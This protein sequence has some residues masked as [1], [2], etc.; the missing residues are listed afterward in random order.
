MQDDHDDLERLEADFY[1]DSLADIEGKAERK[2]RLQRQ[3]REAKD[4]LDAIE[5]D[6]PLGKYLR[7]RRT[8][9]RK[10][11]QVLVET[12]PE[13]AVRIA[14]AQAEIREFL[15]VGEWVLSELSVA[16]EAEQDIK[17]EFGNENG[18]DPNDQD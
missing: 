10:A 3:V 8:V 6:G 1:E 2:N 16:D 9:A 13:H 5:N 11:L 12:P 18:Q 17:E 15:R 7:F 14:A 4:M